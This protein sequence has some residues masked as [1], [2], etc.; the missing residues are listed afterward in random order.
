MNSKAILSVASLGA[1]LM[2]S[3]VSLFSSSS[4]RADEVAPPVA[5]AATA[6]QDRALNEAP[7]PAFKPFS[8]ELNPLAA[9]IGRYS[10]QGEWLPAAHHAIVLNPH[11]DHV[12]ADISESN[13]GASVSYSEGFTGFG[14]ELGYRFYTGEKGA[15]GFYVGPSVLAAHY[16]ASA[17]GLPSTSFNSIGAAVD[18]GGQWILGPGIVVGFGFGL[19]YTSVSAGGDTDGLPLTAA[20]IAGGGVRPRTLLTVGYAF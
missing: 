7:K 17:E 16:S 6:Q 14:S 11:F 8:L 20:I 19:Q 3:L 9:A 13:N 4:A 10:I 2:V 18:A 1:T 12:S 15:N 5:P